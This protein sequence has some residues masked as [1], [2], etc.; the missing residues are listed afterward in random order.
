[1]IESIIEQM[2]LFGGVIPKMVVDLVAV[3]AF[4]DV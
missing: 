1:M 3:L 2:H 4:W